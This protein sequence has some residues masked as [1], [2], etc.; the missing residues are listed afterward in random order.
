[1]AL[2]DGG[3]VEQV[4]AELHEAPASFLECLHPALSQLRFPGELDMTEITLEIDIQH[5]GAGR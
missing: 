5:K 3:I 1:L 4:R 2:G